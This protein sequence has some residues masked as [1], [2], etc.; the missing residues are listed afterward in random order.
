VGKRKGACIIISKLRLV[1]TR[2]N[3]LVRIFSRSLATVPQYTW[4]SYLLAGPPPEVA[5]QWSAYVLVYRLYHPHTMQQ[6]NDN[7]PFSYD[8]L[9]D[10]SS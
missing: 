2:E 9:P 5:A 1:F 7:A 6:I 8:F 3:V 10:S 4:S